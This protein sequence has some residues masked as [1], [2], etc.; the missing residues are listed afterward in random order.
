MTVHT[1]LG[2]VIHIINIVNESIEVNELSL[3][4]E[5][6]KLANLTSEKSLKALTII[7]HGT[8]N[9]SNKNKSYI[10][11]LDHLRVPTPK[12][13]NPSN[14][15]KKLGSLGLAGKSK[16]PI[17]K[18]KNEPLKLKKLVSTRSNSNLMTI[19]NNSKYSSVNNK[20]SNLLSKSPSQFNRD[21][22]EV[23]TL[24]VSDNNSTPPNRSFIDIKKMIKDKSRTRKENNKSQLRDDIL[25]RSILNAEDTITS[26]QPLENGKTEQVTAG[27]NNNGNDGT[28]NTETNNT[29][30]NTANF[31]GDR[32]FSI[33]DIGGCNFPLLVDESK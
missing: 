12:R 26:S 16:S 29:K 9:D 1:L 25:S 8:S 27:Y 32:K 4:T 2:T 18:P 20:T 5:K 17:L 22:A 3:L 10:N 21:K 24:N 30:L 31:V 23:S 7:E 6:D 14:E 11:L 13:V 19:A 15:Y 28:K 33:L